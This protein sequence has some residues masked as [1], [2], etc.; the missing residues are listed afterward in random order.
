MR[1]GLFWEIVRIAKEL[2]PTWGLFENA[3]GLLSSSGGRDMGLVLTGL[4]ECWPCIGYRVLDSRHWGVAQRRRRLFFVCG[5]D[6]AR[7]AQVL[8][9][10]EG[11]GGHPAARGEAGARVA[12]SPTAGAHRP[13]VNDPGRRHEDDVNLV[14]SHAL[15]VPT[16]NARYDPNGETYVVA[17]TLTAPDTNA[18]PING[19][20]QDG[21]R[22]DKIPVVVVNALDQRRGGA[23]D[24][25]AQ[26]GHL[27]AFQCHGNNVG[28]MGTLRKGDGGLTSGVLFVTHT[29]K[30]EGHDAVVANTLQNLDATKPDAVAHGMS[31]R[32]LTPIETNRLQGFP[33]GW[34]CG[35]QPLDAYTADPESAAERC[36]CPDGPVY[37]QMGNAVTVPVILWLGQRLRAA[38]ASHV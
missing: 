13:G 26:V 6:E 29:L 15:S 33:D 5:P 1:S 25:E 37:R 20:R 4:R 3:P 19:K 11:G 8:F 18:K 12:A 24:N 21:S 38:M 23:D 30:A 22:S 27:I 31:V 34:C 10:S 2:Q 28:A 7:V 17:D 9:E 35:C 36:T 32:R 14:L 16:S